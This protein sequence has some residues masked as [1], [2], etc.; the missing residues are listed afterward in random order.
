MVYQG[1]HKAFGD[2]HVLRGL[3]LVVPAERITVVIGR[4]GTGKSVTIKHI[5]GLLRPD[6]GHIWVGDDELTT[7]SDR[8]LRHIRLRFGM[9]FQHAALFDS[10][11]VFENVAF[12]LR[13]HERLREA[14]VRA[15][16]GAL[17]D[18]VGLRGA[19]R[20]IPSE[21][22]GGMR[23]RVGLARA[24]VRDPAYLL[25]DE[26]TTGLDPILTAAMDKLIADTQRAHP[27]LTS[28]VI[29][30]DMHAVLSI[31]DKIVMLV[32][33]RVAHEGTPDWFRQ[34]DDAL[35]RQFLSGSLDGPM[36]V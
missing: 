3:D 7:M 18:A 19:E 4:S 27:G 34:S 36:K 33:G 35:V 2:H 9:V 32:D 15:K 23:K 13:Q 6:A 11:D 24:L 12:P 29:S 25:Y 28:L 22:S 5:M 30:H 31:A 14:E 26:P 20:K 1:V 17:L 8:E 16:V 10:M 21:L